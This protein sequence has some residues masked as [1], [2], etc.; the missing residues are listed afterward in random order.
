MEKLRKTSLNPAYEYRQKEL[1]TAILYSLISLF[2]D[3]ESTSY[4]TRVAEG[5]ISGILNQDYGKAKAGNKVFIVVEGNRVTINRQV[6]NESGDENEEDENEDED[7][8][9]IDSFEVQVVPPE[10]VRDKEKM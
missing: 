3:V 7:W 1:N 4:N 9:E 10:I 8:E 5:S 2:E 6:A